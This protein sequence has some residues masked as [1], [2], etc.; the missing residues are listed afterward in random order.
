LRGVVDEDAAWLDAKVHHLAGVNRRE[1]AGD[2]DPDAEDLPEIEPARAG[3]LV[4]RLPGEALEDER[5]AALVH[6]ESLGPQDPWDRE[7]REDRE[8][9]TEHRDL[10]RR[11]RVAARRLEDDR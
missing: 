10:P 2:G 8:L 5:C 7:I 1:R 11:L 9:M 3:E 4:E 6:L